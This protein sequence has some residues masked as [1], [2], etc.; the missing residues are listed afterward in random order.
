M[1]IKKAVIAV[2]GFGTRFLPATKAV[3]KELFPIINTPILEI[4]VKELS[5]AGIEQICMIISRG[6]ESILRHF[7]RNVEVELNLKNK[8]K[9]LFDLVTNQDKYAKISY[10]IQKE[11]LGFADAVSLSR[12]F[13][14]DDAFVL[15]VGDEVFFGEKSLTMQLIECYEEYGISC[16]ALSEVSPKETKLYGIA[17][18][19]YESNTLSLKGFV[20]KP[21]QNPPSLFAN[22][23]RYVMTPEIFECIECF[24]GACEEINFIDC[25]NKL[26]KIRGLNGIVGDGVR[27]DTGSKLGFIKA[28]IFASLKD[29]ELKK[30]I[31][32]FMR[33]VVKSD[34][35]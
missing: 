24:R 34:E 35:V 13:V 30:D 3:P 2:A 12:G 7:D 4:L 19:D 29:E 16:V 18:I 11:P 1:Q 10:M 28:N 14:G 15:C 6:K 17:D 31:I 9:V 20:E 8:N 23:G 27:F 22:I 26:S 25:L 5:E 33:E 32:N 21:M